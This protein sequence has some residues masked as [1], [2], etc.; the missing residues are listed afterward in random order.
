MWSFLEIMQFVSDNRRI[1]L[2]VIIGVALTALI[3]Q[4]N[5]MFK[6]FREEINR[7]E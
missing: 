6:G 5:E 7:D 1:I 4:L 3:R 2:P